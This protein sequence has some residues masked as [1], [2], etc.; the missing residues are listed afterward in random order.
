MKSP[1]AFATP[2]FPPVKTLVQ[3]GYP[4]PN[5]WSVN[6]QYIVPGIPRIPMFPWSTFYG[7]R[8]PP[9]YR[10][11]DFLSED[12]KNK[13]AVGG[14]YDPQYWTQ[15]IKLGFCTFISFFIIFFFQKKLYV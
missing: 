13:I 6:K 5:Y 12:K 10:S 11:L 4:T 9:I 3:G 8:V 14:S 7:R 1:P 15:S 2:T